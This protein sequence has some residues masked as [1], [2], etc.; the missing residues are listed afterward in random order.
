MKRILISGLLLLTGCPGYA[1]RTIV[2]DLEN[3]SATIRW[4]LEG[5]DVYDYNTIVNDYVRGDTLNQEHPGWTIETKRLEPV[6]DELHG[7]A[8]LTFSGAGDV[9]ITRAVRSDYALRF[10]PGANEMVKAAN[11]QARTPSGCVLWK[12]G[13]K[14]L[15]IETVTR[16]HE[17]R[18]S[19]LK[20]YEADDDR[21][22]A[23]S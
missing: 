15:R 11:A 19:L 21:P 4:V 3:E 14:V 17:N 20:W 2:V 9:G 8:E 18:S 7:V 1:R 12:E 10:C 6:G 22:E 5:A 23:K 16:G 13:V